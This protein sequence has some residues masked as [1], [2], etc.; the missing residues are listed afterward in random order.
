MAGDTHP[1]THLH[2]HGQDGGTDALD[3]ILDAALDLTRA[4]AGGVHLDT[5]E[6]TVLDC[7]DQIAGLRDIA[8]TETGHPAPLDQVI[9]GDVHAS[10]GIL[11]AVDG[12]TAHLVRALHADPLERTGMWASAAATTW[13]TIW[14]HRAAQAVARWAGPLIRGVADDQQTRQRTVYRQIIRALREA[15]HPMTTI[16]E[17]LGITRATAYNYLDNSV[18]GT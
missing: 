11:R 14:G 5:D 2:H 13:W 10:L 9:H 7:C 6:K 15:G 12:G 16:A 17:W 8:A 3:R 4:E 18:S 1:I